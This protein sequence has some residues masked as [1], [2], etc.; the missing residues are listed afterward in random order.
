MLSPD[1]FLI[2]FIIVAI[3]FFI[4]FIMGFIIGRGRKIFISDPE[5]KQLTF[6]EDGYFICYFTYE[7]SDLICKI[8]KYNKGN[9]EWKIVQSY[10]VEKQ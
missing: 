2:L 10:K 6:V 5:G 7:A 3:V 1:P 9:R 8:A 4:S